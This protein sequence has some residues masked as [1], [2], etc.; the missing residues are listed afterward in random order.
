[1]VSHTFP[2]FCHEV[3]VHVYKTVEAVTAGLMCYGGGRGC[4]ESTKPG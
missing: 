3:N 2:G 1:M 4:G